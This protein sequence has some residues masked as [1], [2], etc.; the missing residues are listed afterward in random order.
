MHWQ[1]ERARVESELSRL[2]E[3]HSEFDTDRVRELERRLHTLATTDMAVVVSPGQNE[4][5][6]M[7]ALGIDIVPHRQRMNSKP[8]DEKFKDPDDPL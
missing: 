3:Y 2:S 5:E 4:I 6:Q 8:L 7:K 1:A